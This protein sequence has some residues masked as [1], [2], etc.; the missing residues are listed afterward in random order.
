MFAINRLQELGSEDLVEAVLAALNNALSAV[1]PFKLVVEHFRRRGRMITVDGLE[2]DTRSVDDFLVL[3][4]G[5][6]ASSMASAVLRVIGDVPVRGVVVVPHGAKAERN[7]EP[8][9]IFHSGHP[10]PD[11]NSVKAGQAFLEHAKKSGEKSFAI[12]LI[13][14]GAS[15]LVAL[16]AEGVELEDKRAVTKALLDAGASID[17]L[18]TVRKHLSSLKGGWLAK[19]LRCRTVSLILSDVVGDRLDV[20]GSGP[21]VPDPTT[22]RD[23]V[24]IL[25]KYRVQAPENVVKRLELGAAG[26]LPETPKPGDPVF[27]RV[28]NIVIGRNADAVKAAAAEMK[29][30]KYRTVALTSGLVGE[31]REAAKLFAAIIRDISL[32]NIPYR[33]PASVLAGGETTV[34]V[35]GTGKGGR[36]Q[37]LALATAI[38]LK[39]FGNFVFASIG[40]DGVDGPTDAAGALCTE[41]TIHNAVSAGLEPQ[42]FLENND[43]YNFFDRVGGLIK[44]GPTGTNV[45]DL[46]ILVVRGKG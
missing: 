29:R 44:T 39:D 21:T 17:E 18:N 5:K 14:G 10:T 45:G 19:N 30:R 12:I 37:E 27:R 2:V 1:D 9:E 3:A 22:Y 32:N 4:A 41:K 13:S 36:N 15:A 24:N 38:L 31:A 43:S 33:P 34:S 23:A 40:T 16:P 28:T 20:I 6:A 46:M 8:L 42:Q 25:K 26:A 35:K 7:L 11:Q